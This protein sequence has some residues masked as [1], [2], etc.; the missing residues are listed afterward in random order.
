MSR[1]PRPYVSDVKRDDATMVYV[2]MDKMG[3]G[4]RP[5][6]LPKN[7]SEGPKGLEHVGGSAGGGSSAKGKK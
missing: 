4:A 6:G 3:I 1:F 7:A 2:P 5:S